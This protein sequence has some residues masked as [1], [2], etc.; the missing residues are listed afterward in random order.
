MRKRRRSWRNKMKNRWGR[1]EREERRKR[2]QR[3]AM[4]PRSGYRFISPTPDRF[5]P[6]TV[7][8]SYGNNV[9]RDYSNEGD[10]GDDDHGVYK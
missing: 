8:F 4:R 9:L 10:N 3:I 6:R 2:T 5:H 1:G 7:V